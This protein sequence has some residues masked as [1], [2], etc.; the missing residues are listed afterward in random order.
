MYKALEKKARTG[1]WVYKL[2]GET[3][4]LVGKAAQFLFNY[5]FDEELVPEESLNTKR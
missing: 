3:I 5:T 4:H 1:S 2:H